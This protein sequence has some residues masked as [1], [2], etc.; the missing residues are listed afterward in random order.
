MKTIKVLVSFL[1]LVFAV[2]VG[3]SQCDKD[4]DPY[5]TVKYKVNAQSD[6]CKVK[7]ESAVKDV[8]GVKTVALNLDTKIV[9]TSYDKD[10]TNE[11]AI[12]KVITDLGYTAEVVKINT[13]KHKNHPCNRPCGSHK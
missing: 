9:A 11:D 10:D 1:V 6:D 13:S 12:A 4:K 2:Q 7:I 3:Y 8:D 5:S